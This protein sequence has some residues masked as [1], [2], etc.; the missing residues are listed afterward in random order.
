MQFEAKL[1]QS[2]Q[3]GREGKQST[4]LTA[5]RFSFSVLFA[6][7]VIGA[8]RSAQGQSSNSAQIIQ[9]TL[10]IFRANEHDRPIPNALW[11]ALVQ[12]LHDE[13]GS[14]VPELR[15]AVNPSGMA[16]DSD[17]AVQILRGD[18]IAPGIVVDHPIAVYLHGDCTTDPGVRYPIGEKREISGPLGWVLLDHGHIKPFIHVDCDRLA[19]VLRTSALTRTD[20]DRNQRMASAIAHVIL[21]EWIHIA[22]QNAHHAH[23]GLAK[24]EFSVNDLLSPSALHKAQLSPDHCEHHSG[25]PE[26]SKGGR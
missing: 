18:Q 16:I 2:V 26:L 24:A 13:L 19:Q 25:A 15:E 11:S 9:P 10:A 22:S 5:L 14:G 4:L 17:R 21:H 7:I 6:F 3:R 1:S 20:G 8:W 12:A 23:S